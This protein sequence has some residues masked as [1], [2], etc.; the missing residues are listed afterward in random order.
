[1]NPNDSCGTTLT[2][3]FPFLISHVQWKT[4][5]EGGSG[6]GFMSFKYL[7]ELMG[8]KINMA[9]LGGVTLIAIADEDKSTRGEHEATM[10][11]VWGQGAANGELGLGF[12]QPKSA[13]RP[14]RCETLNGIAVLD[15][16]AGQNTT[17][18]EWTW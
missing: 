6:Q 4:T 16:A 2:N 3:I 13:T 18:C 10:G 14:Q 1:M 8:C 5:G 11:I 15:V 9:A 12:D 17:F 7:H